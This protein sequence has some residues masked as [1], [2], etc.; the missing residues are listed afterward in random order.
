MTQSGW[1]K[2]YQKKGLYFYEGAKSNRKYATSNNII[3]NKQYCVLSMA[4]C[5]L[6][7]VYRILN[8]ARCM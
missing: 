3:Y 6:C 8:T 1:P 4:Y 2:S 5:L 7:T